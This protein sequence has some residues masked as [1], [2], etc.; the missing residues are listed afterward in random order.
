MSLPMEGLV[1]LSCPL[2]SLVISRVTPHWHSP[3]RWKSRERKSLSR[4][5]QRQ[6]GTSGGPFSTDCTKPRGVS[7]RFPA[8]PR[9]SCLP[10]GRGTSTDTR[11]CTA[12]GGRASCLR[13]ESASLA[14]RIEG[15]CTWQWSMWEAFL[16]PPPSATV[17]QH[18]ALARRL[19]VAEAVLEDWRLAECW[20][21]PQQPGHQHLVRGLWGDASPFHHSPSH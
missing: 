17:W 3:A 9:L 16:S 20:L 5:T 15:N 4:I 8:S 14:S 6:G 12:R 1:F 13:C 10:A 2:T 11:S 7:Q 18:V 21:H 19:S